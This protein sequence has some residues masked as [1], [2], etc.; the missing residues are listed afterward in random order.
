MFLKLGN[1]P[2]YFKTWVNPDRFESAQKLTIVQDNSSLEKPFLK[3][4]FEKD[5]SFRVGFMILSINSE[6][7]SKYSKKFKIYQS[8]GYFKTW[9]NPD[10]FLIAQKLAIV[11]DNSS[12]EESF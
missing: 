1:F 12:L 3:P 7:P 8:L 6:A 11:H 5:R 2:G 9:V 10:R 4:I